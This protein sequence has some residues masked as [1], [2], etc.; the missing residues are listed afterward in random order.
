MLLLTPMLAACAR[1]QPPPAPPPSP[2][3][4]VRRIA[5]PSVVNLVG[6]TLDRTIDELRPAD[7][8]S[9]VAVSA[10]VFLTD[11]RNLVG[12]DVVALATDRGVGLAVLDPEYYGEDICVLRSQEIVGVPVKGVRDAA[13]VRPGEQVFAVAD[14]EGDG[15]TLRPAVITARQHD[16]VATWLQTTIAV[17][18]GWSGGAIFDAQGNLLGLAMRPRG[19]AGRQVAAFSLDAPL[20]PTRLA[21]VGS[22]DAQGSDRL[23]AI[24]L[25][26]LAPSPADT[27]AGS[28]S[29]LQPTQRASLDRFFMQRDR[30]N[31]D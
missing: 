27:S 31:G 26:A 3:E 16:E 5:A 23:L 18:S 28:L 2:A 7:S 9:A 11:C 6:F 17:T 21:R 19:I 24:V 22:D 30:A 25:P 14:P 10:D 1:P 20:L 13:T 4:Q 29:A 12:A 8:G 15:P